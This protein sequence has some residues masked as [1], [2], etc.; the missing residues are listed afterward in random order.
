MDSVRLQRSSLSIVGGSY[1]PVSP[2]W[3]ALSRLGC[4]S[5]HLDSHPCD[6]SVHFQRHQTKSVALTCRILIVQL[7]WDSLSGADVDADVASLT[8]KPAAKSAQASNPHDGGKSSMTRDAGRDFPA[9]ED[10]N[11]A[12]DG[13]KSILKGGKIYRKER[14][15]LM[16]DEERKRAAF[17][18]ARK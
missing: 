3:S 10:G 15:L 4:V 11:V 2:H 14:D 6:V 17:D 5:V 8:G 18:A 9:D 13:A 1:T 12:E 7:G 16:T